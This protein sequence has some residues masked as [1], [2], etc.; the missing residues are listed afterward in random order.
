MATTI[1]VQQDG[2]DFYVFDSFDELTAGR[3]S[4]IESAPFK[5]QDWDQNAAEKARD[6]FQENGYFKGSQTARFV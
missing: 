4:R 6:W 3:V 2:A 1:Y 5:V